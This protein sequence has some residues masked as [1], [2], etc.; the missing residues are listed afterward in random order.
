MEWEKGTVLPSYNS[1][2]TGFCVTDQHFS[3]MRA[4]MVASQ[5][6]T[7]AVSDPKVVAAMEAVAREDFV[8]KERAGLAYVDVPITLGNGRSLNAPLVTGRLIVEAQIKATDTVLLI[9]AATGYTAAVLASLAKQVVA[10]ESVPDLA[11]QAR[12]NLEAFDSVTFFEGALTAGHAALA[13]YDVVI[14][15]GAVETV[16][17]LLWGQLKTGG[18]MAS[19]LVEQGVTRLAI[20]RQFDGTGALVPFADA[21]VAILPG[22]STPRAFEF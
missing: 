9:G 19:G 14:I 8:P 10:V 6:R 15:D 1:C 17:A 5:L 7:N 12:R 20:G 13:P 21:E 18:V 22:F 11:A 4:A 3:E 2:A 16:P